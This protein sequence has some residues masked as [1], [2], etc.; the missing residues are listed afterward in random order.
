MSMQQCCNSICIHSHT[1]G[2]RQKNTRGAHTC[3]D[4]KQ[5]MAHTTYRRSRC[6]LWLAQQPQHTLNLGRPFET[7]P[8]KLAVAPPTTAVSAD[9]HLLQ[10][11]VLSNYQH[12]A[13]YHITCNAIS[14]SLDLQ[15]RVMSNCRKHTNC[16]KGCDTLNIRR[17]STS[18]ALVEHMRAV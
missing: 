1:H 15:P 16:I 6:V 12:I 18:H 13:S 4:G 2:K 3:T 14:G 8:N 10:L 7:K 5:L 17:A 9:R 11:L